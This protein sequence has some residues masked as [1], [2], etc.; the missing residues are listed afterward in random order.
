MNLMELVKALIEFLKAH[1]SWV[2]G[3][4]LGSLITFLITP[5]IVILVVLRLPADYFSRPAGRR[6]RLFSRYPFFYQIFLLFKN[7]IGLI[8]IMT[9]FV[10]LFAPGQGLLTILIG[11]MLVNFPGKSRLERFVLSRPGVRENLNKLRQ[12]FGQPP[13]EM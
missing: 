12:R 13:L 10:L 6:S 11:L 5:L 8:L 1:P 2:K 3:L 9:G 4:S 7:L